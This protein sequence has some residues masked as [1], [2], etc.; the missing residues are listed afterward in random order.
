MPRLV[1]SSLLLLF[2]GA[3]LC[4]TGFSQDDQAP[5]KFS[6]KTYST[7]MEVRV[8]DQAGNFVPGLRRDD[9]QVTVKSRS[10]ELLS[11]KEEQ[12]TPTS[13]AIL[14]DL[15]S[16]MQEDDIRT[17]KQA[18]LDL[19]HLMPRDDELLLAVYNRDVD[20]LSSLTTDRPEVLE[21]LRNVSP[22]GRVG[23]WKRLSSAFGTAALTGYAIDE[24]LL[25]LKSARYQNKVVLVFSSAFGNLGRGTQDHLREAGAR[26]FAVGWK[27]SLGDAFNLWGDKTSQKE[28]LKRT[29]GAKY[30]GPEILERLDR[31]RTAMTSFYLLAYA[32]SQEEE[33]DE[34]VEIRIVGHPEYRI[35]SLRR[36]AGQNAFY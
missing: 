32:P 10:R 2:G 4:G 18:I 25:R 11:F 23:F 28:L 34:D 33:N 9:F 31:L 19:I 13:L 17:A 1:A 7:L 6:V 29:A 8:F 14:I 36:T 27:N 12:K 35:S 15:G 3:L 24:A 16:S 30:S 20:F 5:T 21:G 22:E 26:L